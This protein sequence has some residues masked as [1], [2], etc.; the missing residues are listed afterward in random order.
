MS[1][2]PSCRAANEGLFDLT[3][4]LARL[5]G[6]AE[7]I[8][9]GDQRIT[10]QELAQRVECLAAALHAHGVRRGSRIALLTYDSLPTIE[11]LLAAA[12][13]GAVA[14]PLN[15]RLNPAEIAYVLEDAAPVA[16]FVHAELLE[17]AQA[18]APALGWV[19]VDNDDFLRYTE[20][21]ESAFVPE[22]VEGDDGWVQLYTSGTTGKPKGCLLAQS[23][24]RRLGIE[25]GLRLALSPAD[26][27]VLTAPLFHSG[28][29]GQVVAHM[30]AGARIVI[31]ARGLDARQMRELWSREGCTHVSPPPTLYQQLMDLQRDEPVPLKIRLFTMAAS[32]NPPQLVQGVMDTFACRTIHG[33]GQTEIC[34]FAAFLFGEEQVARPQALGQPLWSVEARVVDDE[35]CTLPS[36]TPGE[37]LL[38]GPS[39]ML[40]YHGLPDATEATL[41]DGW[42]HTGDVVRI[43]ADGYWYFVSRK[44]ELIKTLGENVYPAEVEHRLLAHAAVRECAVFGVPDERYGE[45]V[46]AAIVLHAGQQVTREEVSAWCREVLAAYKRPRY[47]E[48]LEEMPRSAIGK[49]HTL[50][51]KERPTD[52]EQAAP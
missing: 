32:M 7:A 19:V 9:D 29:V 22:P 41:Q 2:S 35:G 17:L 25:I 4:R 5:F 14:V 28:G 6:E 20:K 36:D 10:W 52:S 47:V 31:P 21:G 37:L 11:L 23:G 26:T 30:M 27:F 12:Q 44:K 42:L 34:G 40:G 43:D 39:V 8:V 3:S 15:W 50:M 51:L 1:I 16:S 13:L 48:F 38:R 49:I 46:K 18:A 45:A 24:W 33:F